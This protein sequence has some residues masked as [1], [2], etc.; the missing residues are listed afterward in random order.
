MP[1]GIRCNPFLYKQEITISI[2]TVPKWQSLFYLNTS[3]D[4]LIPPRDLLILPRPLNDGNRGHTS[5]FARRS[6]DFKFLQNFCAEA[7]LYYGEI[8]DEIASAP[9]VINDNKPFPAHRNDEDRWLTS[10]FARRST[11]FKL[12]QTLCAEAISNYVRISDE[13]ARLYS[14]FGHASAP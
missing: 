7:I 11:N 9:E 6:S 12:L 10:V 14:P 2:G 1:T 8:S 4:L 5:V 13:I 3:G